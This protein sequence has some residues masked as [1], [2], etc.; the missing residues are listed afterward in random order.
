MLKAIKFV[1][2]FIS[3]QRR[4]WFLYILIGFTPN[5]NNFHTVHS[6]NEKQEISK[7]I[8]GASTISKLFS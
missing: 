2:I 7:P 1:P 3:G 4:I 5:K 6:A 8:K